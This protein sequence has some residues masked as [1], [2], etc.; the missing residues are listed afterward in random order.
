[1]PKIVNQNA[2]TDDNWGAVSIKEVGNVEVEEIAASYF[3]P[4]TQE[5]SHN[6]SHNN[7]NVSQVTT[8][9]NSY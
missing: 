5:N 2:N 7:K 6:A 1:M 4:K 3:H 9:R 8:L